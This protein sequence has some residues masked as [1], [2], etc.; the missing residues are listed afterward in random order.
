MSLVEKSSLLKW[1]CWMTNSLKHG[2]VIKWKHFPRYWPGPRLIPL[3]KPSD[4]E[5]SCFLWSSPEPTIEQAMKTP[6]IW[7]A[8]ALIMTSLLLYVTDRRD[9]DT[10]YHELEFSSGGIYIWSCRLAVFLWRYRKLPGTIYRLWERQCM[11]NMH[12]EN[13]NIRLK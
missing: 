6:V 9:I 13:K 1:P 3:T 12:Q 8:I 4:A 11:Y 2:D 7:D 10:R 5:L